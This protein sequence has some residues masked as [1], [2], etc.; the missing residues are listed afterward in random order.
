MYVF[1]GVFVDGMR[2]VQFN[3]L[4]FLSGSSVGQYNCECAWELE[5]KAGSLEEQLTYLA[6][7]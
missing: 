5:R 3:C 6:S 7:G 2:K 1:G 4:S